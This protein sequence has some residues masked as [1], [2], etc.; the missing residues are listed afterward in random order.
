M[1][2]K[3]MDEYAGLTIH[4]LVKSIRK[5]ENYYEFVQIPKRFRSKT[6]IETM[7]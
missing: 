5:S 1:T 6:V 7:V 4:Y 2:L 3:C